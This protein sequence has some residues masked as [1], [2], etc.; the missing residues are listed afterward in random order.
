LA[1][2]PDGLVGMSAIVENSLKAI[3]ALRRE[4][5]R[6]HC[7]TN[8][9]AQHFT[10]NVLLSCGAVP[11]MTIA[12]EEI[13]DFVSQADGLLINLGTMDISRTYSSKKAAEIAKK[14]GKPFV[15]DPVFV[16]AS[17]PRL[18][19]AKE[20]MKEC[21]V[22]VRAN[23]REGKALFGEGFEKDGIQKIASRQSGCI[24][25]TG[26][27]D[28][29]ID[30]SQTLI[31]A[32]GAPV[33]TKITAM[34]CALTGLMAA[35][36]SV[37]ENAIIAATAALLWYNISSEIAAEKSSGPGTFVPHFLDVLAAMDAETIAQRAD[38]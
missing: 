32:T 13:E 23:Q 6:V 37:E 12:P 14:Q 30:G 34:G 1:A 3:A 7:I 11:S 2:V 35:L 36:A 26:E 19:L 10:A 22:I 8:T 18:K 5:P 9:V 27:L 4:Q 24:V 33:M 20:L 29:V 38:L 16:Q 17:K 25:I 31:T 28:A 21:P 15:L